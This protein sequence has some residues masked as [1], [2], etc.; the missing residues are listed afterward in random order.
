MT[1]TFQSNQT[2][3]LTSVAA[4]DGILH[5]SEEVKNAA[6]AVPQTMVQGIIINGIL[7][8]GFLIALLFTMG[9]VENALE[10]P[11]GYPIIEIFY[12]ATHSVTATNGLMSL[13]LI[14]AFVALFGALASVTRLTWAFARDRGLPFSDFFAY[15]GLS[16]LSIADLGKLSSDP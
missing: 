7:A 14:T 11:T 9:N 10:S 3:F 1:L 16:L 8:F 6:V 2:S 4:F 12:Q 13:I 5:M 15:V